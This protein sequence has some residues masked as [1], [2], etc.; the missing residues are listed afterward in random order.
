MRIDENSRKSGK[1]MEW[2]DAGERTI[3]VGVAGLGRFGKLHAAALLAMPGVEIAAVCDP[4]AEELVWAKAALGVEA[5]YTRFDRFLLHEAM[6][7]IFLVTPEDQH[8]PM[9]LAAI[10]HGLPV[11][12]EKPLAT[13]AQEGEAVVTAA[14]DAGIYL[15]LGFVLRFDTQHAHLHDEI[16]RGNFGQIV[17]MHARRNCSKAWF[18]IYGDR[19]HSVF[20][21]IIHDIDI[22]LW[23]L[24]DRCERVYAVERHLTGHKY[25]DACVATLQFAGGAVVTLESS[26]MLPTRAPANVLT[27][28]W[29]GTI[30][31]ELNV[32]GVEQ[33]ARMRMLESGLEIWTGEVAQHPD[34]GLWPL[35]HGQIGGALRAE[36]EHFIQCVRMGQASK[37]ASLDDA[38][39]GLRIAEAI[40]QSAAEGREVL[41]P[42]G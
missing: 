34:A 14:R 30:D 11:F 36:D 29:Y 6:D 31:A 9:A 40:V 33:S 19:A 20:E 21:T 12:M 13:S 2:V 27:E 37:V 25:P 18:E 23:F 17:T 24:Q 5:G 4:V 26:W 42:N 15:Q 39:A 28:T 7:A 22:A 35:V 38:L 8:A 16:E 1:T 41:L 32:T 10:A 3:R